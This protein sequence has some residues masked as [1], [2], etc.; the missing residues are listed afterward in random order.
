MLCRHC[1]STVFVVLKND[2]IVVTDMEFYEYISKDFN[3][4]YKHGIFHSYG[5]PA[6]EFAEYCSS[7]SKK[8][9]FI[10]IH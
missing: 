7:L 1:S 10:S 4:V 2:S 3:W 5:F 9:R 6:H 8:S